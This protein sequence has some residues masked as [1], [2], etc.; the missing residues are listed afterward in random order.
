MKKLDEISIEDIC[1]RARATG[2][3]CGQTERTDTA[4]DFTI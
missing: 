4:A 3:D 2:L 1:K